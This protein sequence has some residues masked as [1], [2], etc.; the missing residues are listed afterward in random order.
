MS[1]ADEF[2][3]AA[4]TL[5]DHPTPGPGHWR[6]AIS[7]A[8][9]AAF[10]AIVEAATET[11]FATSTAQEAARQWF[12]HGKV[13][14]IAQTVGDATGPIPA[15]GLPRPASAEHR[16]FCVRL[17]DLYSKR[18]TA[19]YFSAQALGLTESDARSAVANARA[20]C[21]QLAIWQSAHDS[22]FELIALAMLRKSVNAK[23]R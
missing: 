9:Y 19:D 6:R 5:L 10:H 13:A 14:D 7:T 15:V 3:A 11:L 22:D 23:N 17:R 8:Y 12:E 20:I 2:L 4:Q 21:A 16:Q 18:Q 1:T